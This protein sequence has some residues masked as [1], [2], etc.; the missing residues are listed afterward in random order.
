M[1]LLARNAQPAVVA[2]DLGGISDGPAQL[3]RSECDPLSKEFIVPGWL[4]R[5]PTPRNLVNYLAD[6][7]GQTFSGGRQRKLAIPFAANIR[8][9]KQLMKRCGDVDLAARVIKYTAD[10]TS[11]DLSFHRVL[12][13]IDEVC[14]KLR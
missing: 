5:N 9:A 13:R 1:S 6:C 7:L 2:V 11:Y 8:P 4:N 12:D 10:K 14:E 3:T